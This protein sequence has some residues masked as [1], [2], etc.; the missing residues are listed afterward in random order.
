M[1]NKSILSVV[2][3]IYDFAAYDLWMQP[4]GLLRLS[5]QLK[6]LGFQVDLI[7]CLDRYD[8]DLLKR[9]NRE[10]PKNEQKYGCGKFYKERVEK[11]QILKD[12]PLYYNRYGLPVDIFEKK[13]D[14]FSRPPDV[15][16]V[17][18]VMTYWYPGTQL[19][20]KILRKRFPSSIIML[21]GIYPILMPE[22][23]IKTS[24]ADQIVSFSGFNRV[25]DHIL[26]VLGV[27][28]IKTGKD[29][30][31]N[32]TRID[33]SFLTDKRTAV[34]ETSKGC[35]QKCRYCSQHIINKEQFRLGSIKVVNDIEYYKNKYSSKYVVFYD[36]A[37]AYKKEKY[38]I[39]ILKGVKKLLLKDISFH[40][41]NGI[42]VSE[43]NE[44]LAVLLKECNFK[45][46]RLSLESSLP[47]RQLE[48]GGKVTNKDFKEAVRNLIYAG[49]KPKEIEVYMMM[50]LP[51]QSVEE[52]KDGINYVFDSGA[53]PVLTSYSPT[54]GSYYYEKFFKEKLKDP[55]MHNSTIFSLNT[56]GIDEEMIKDLRKNVKEKKTAL[57]N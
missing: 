45:T 12:I 11:P 35:P 44:E 10:K 50:G 39:P 55:L 31:E 7:N 22:H 8:Y 25:F 30:F 42:N 9:L 49:F 27:R 20:I 38:L 14:K 52:I 15:I 21:G 16:L 56:E 17:S 29:T 48:T 23:A 5:T 6:N 1:K 47:S 33:Y 40:L 28:N 43:I 41:P 36:D 54:P 32:I 51:G 46:L 24:G 4:L 26:K 57:Y 3:W 18:Q 13:L 53:V 37:V 19:A 34:I 2:P